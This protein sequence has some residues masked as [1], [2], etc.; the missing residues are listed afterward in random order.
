MVCG[1]SV[2]SRCTLTSLNSRPYERI[3]ICGHMLKDIG[4]VIKELG[5][6]VDPGWYTTVTNA[7]H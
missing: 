3:R 7:F 2:I 4:E 1:L 5:H 6:K